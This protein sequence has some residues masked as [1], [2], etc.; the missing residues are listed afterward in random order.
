MFK[1]IQRVHCSGLE[2]DEDNEEYNNVWNNKT[3]Q[4]YTHWVQYLN[5]KLDT[6]GYMQCTKFN[7]GYVDMDSTRND[8]LANGQ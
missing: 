1:Y 5:K 6:N 2:K 7:L 3:K 4:M 8:S